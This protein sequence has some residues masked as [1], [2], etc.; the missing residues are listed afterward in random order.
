MDAAGRLRLSH[1]R[2]VLVA[3]RLEKSRLANEIRSSDT[4]PGRKKQ[5]VQRYSNL[6]K[7]LRMTARELEVFLAATRA[8]DPQ[9]L[10]QIFVHPRA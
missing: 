4:T 9:H 6:A 7:E 5:A 10:H 2:V 8:E 1:L 3:G